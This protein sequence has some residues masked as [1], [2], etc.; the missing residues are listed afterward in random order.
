MEQDRAIA[1]VDDAVLANEIDVE[2]A[3]EQLEEA[4][5]ELER[6]ERGE[7][8]ADRWQIE[9]RIIHAENQTR[10]GRQRRNE[11]L[12]AA[13]SAV[14]LLLLAA[15][16][17]IRCAARH[18]ANCA[19]L[20]TCPDHRGGRGVSPQRAHAV[21]L[22]AEGR[23]A[24]P[25]RRSRPTE[26][27]GGSTTLEFTW[28]PASIDFSGSGWSGN[29]VLWSVA[30]TYHGPVLIRGRRLDGHDAS[31]SKRTAAAARAENSGRQ[32]L[33]LWDGARDR[34]SYTRSAPG[35]LRVPG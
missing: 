25:W 32:G 15:V 23:E 34:P 19:G 18:L 20:C 27:G 12:V 5:A 3:Q 10:D 2:R 11:D 21:D 35:L 14:A 29:K 8:E 33:C 13:G 22:G 6:I 28:P 4:Q 16:V 7:S 26:L 9:Q 30:G 17:L 31:A 24:A 1:L